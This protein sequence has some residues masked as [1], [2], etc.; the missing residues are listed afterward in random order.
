LPHLLH[1]KNVY[2][3]VSAR[4]FPLITI[5]VMIAERYA[6]VKWPV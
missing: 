2:F 4:I 5:C 1:E 6:A 3:L